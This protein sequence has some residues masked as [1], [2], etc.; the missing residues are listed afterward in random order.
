MRL[1]TYIATALTAASLLFGSKAKASDV[2]IIAG[3]T[4]VTLDAKV[5]LDVAPRVGLYMRNITGVD[6][7]NAMNYFGLVDA[8]VNIIPG[9]DVVVETQFVDGSV[10]PRAG[11]QY[12]VEAGN[13]SAYVLA[14]AQLAKESNAEILTELKYSPEVA[15]G[16]KLVLSI[17]NITNAAGNGHNFSIQRLRTG[18]QMSKY[19]FGVGADLL[20]EGEQKVPSYNIG[21]FGKVSF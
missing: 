16:L 18:L 1:L 20:E 13:F 14:T 10:V 5:Q 11:M 4:G 7:T 2:E 19:T 6:Y 3:N 8:T 17:E 12:F 21:G 15:D 9:L